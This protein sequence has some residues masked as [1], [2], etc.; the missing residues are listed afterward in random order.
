MALALLMPRLWPVWLTC[1]LLGGLSRLV[2]GAHYLSDTI[3]GLTFGAGFVILA[4]RWLAQR[5]S[6]FVFGHGWIPKRKR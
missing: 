5:G 1:A 3:A 6:M 4:A 2:L